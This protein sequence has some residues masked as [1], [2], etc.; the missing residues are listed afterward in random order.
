MLS[1]LRFIAGVL[2]TLSL[3]YMVHK[4]WGWFITPA[5][6]IDAPSFSKSVGIIL[7][8]GTFKYDLAQ[9]IN[10]AMKAW[11]E[12]AENSEV[13]AKKAFSSFLC[14]LFVWVALGVSYVYYR[15]L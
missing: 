10:I 15:A 2:W 3:G 4:E 11:E 7:F 5:F 14:V 8:A 9:C 13:E 12:G 6:H 1:L